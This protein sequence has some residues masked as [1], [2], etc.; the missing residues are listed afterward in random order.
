MR[1]SRVVGLGLAAGVLLLAGCTTYYKVTDPASGRSYY[2]TSKSLE[3]AKASGAIEFEDDAT[4]KLIVLS[5]SEREEIS[6][7]DYDFAMGKDTEK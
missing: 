6:K 5:A 2:T 1:G 7:H 4:G 3:K